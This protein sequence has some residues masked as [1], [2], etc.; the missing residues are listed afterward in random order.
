MVY[1]LLVWIAVPI[2]FGQ[3]LGYNDCSRRAGPPIPSTVPIW[4]GSI[5]TFFDDYRPLADIDRFVSALASKY[6]N[7]VKIKQIGTSFQGRPIRV[8]EMTNGWGE[9]PLVYLQGGIHAREWIATST[10]L[11]IAHTMLS[12]AAAEGGN[13]PVST[14]L[15]GFVFAFVSPLNPDGYV[16]S[17][18]VNRYWRKT[19]DNRTRCE[20]AA[21]GVDGNRNWGF[22]TGLLISA[23]G[24]TTRSDII[25]PCLDTYEGTAP[26]SEPETM[27]VKQYV[28]QSQNRSFEKST[29]NLQ[30]TQVAAP[31]YV[32][33]FLDY[34]SF[35]MM[36]LPPWGYSAEWPTPPDGPY[37]KELCEKMAGAIQ[38][39]SG[40]IFFSGPDGL[41]ADPGT[42]PD[43]AYGAMG[44]RAT[45]TV[46]LE[47]HT[48]FCLGKEKIKPVGLEQ[49]EAVVALVDHLV[50]KGSH[51]SREFG[52]WAG[53]PPPPP[54]GSASAK[55]L[56][57]QE[58]IPAAS[59]GQSWHRQLVTPVC[60]AAAS[61]AVAF[62]AAASWRKWKRGWSQSPTQIVEADP[63]CIE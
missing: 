49:Y 51:P 44:I 39:S 22:S 15:S 20:S 12:K 56:W 18:E 23:P 16:Y 3:Q 24:S 29:T 32:A 59:H 28:E 35:A 53:M 43:W 9:K 41:P 61:V 62:V 13:G 31:G 2:V 34:H 30:G 36:L 21:S 52:L 5:E 6:A 37:I 26:F 55:K 8:M 42:A 25:D 57:L 4:D 17:W 33:A 45:M 63:E 27:A 48:T 1:H 54:R 46:E 14:M 40:N 11:Y 38:R 58:E 60:V 10:V 47:S 50:A 7:F 19:L